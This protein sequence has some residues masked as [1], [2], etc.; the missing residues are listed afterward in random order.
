MV[1]RYGGG[2][3]RVRCFPSL[4]SDLSFLTVPAVLDKI[5]PWHVWYSYVST[6]RRP[7]SSVILFQHPVLGSFLNLLLGRATS[8]ASPPDRV[9]AADP[10]IFKR[11]SF[12]LVLRF[13]FPPCPRLLPF[14]LCPELQRPFSF[15]AHT[16]TRDPFCHGRA[17]AIAVAPTIGLSLF[18]YAHRTRSCMVSDFSFVLDC[19]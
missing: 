9:N 11:F 2:A 12:F 16:R 1:S 7:L 5:F 13:L 17:C 6:S 8:E 3:V 10:S 18:F 4:S 14:C 15:Y 19:S